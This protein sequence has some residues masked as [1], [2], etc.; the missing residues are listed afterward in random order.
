[1]NIPTKNTELETVAKVLIVDSLKNALILTVGE[2][3]ERPEKSFRPD[4]PGGLVEEGEF[5]KDAAIRETMEEAGIPLNPNDVHLA[6]AKTQ[7]YE[8]ENKSTTK[9]LYTCVIDEAPEITL[10]WEHSAYEWVPLD[11]LLET[12]TFRSFYKEAIEYSLTN[13]LV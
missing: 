10:S 11:T 3:R 2:H 5:E 13:N 7:Y 9:F 8:D 1:M 12:V 6:Y 4:L